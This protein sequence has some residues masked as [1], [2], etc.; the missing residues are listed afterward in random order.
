MGRMIVWDC[1]RERGGRKTAR[2][3]PMGNPPLLTIKFNVPLPDQQLAA[4]EEHR[5]E[6]GMTGT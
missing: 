1:R 2:V 5:F 4:I 6:A 3:P